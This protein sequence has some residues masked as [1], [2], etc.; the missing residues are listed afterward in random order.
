M[1][2]CVRIKV[3]GKVQGVNYRSFIQM[4]ATKLGVEGTIR[5]EEDGS[6]LILVCGPSDK[7][8]DLIDFVYTGSTQSKIE[9]VIVEPMLNNKDFR[10]VFRVI[11]VNSV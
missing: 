7:L 8:D 6:V 9:D 2:K 10:G 4:R 3:T 11:G 1:R 5:N